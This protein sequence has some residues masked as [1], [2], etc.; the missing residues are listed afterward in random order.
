LRVEMMRKMM[1]VEMMTPAVGKEM[2]SKT[3]ETAILLG[4]RRIE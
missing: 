2:A 4:V 1:K 3:L